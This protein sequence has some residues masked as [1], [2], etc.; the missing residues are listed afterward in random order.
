MYVCC[1]K[2]DFIFWVLQCVQHVA[3][4]AY[5]PYLK[6]EKPGWAFL[7]VLNEYFSTLPGTRS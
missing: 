7:P 4:P 2:F 3:L 6:L 5:C 1:A